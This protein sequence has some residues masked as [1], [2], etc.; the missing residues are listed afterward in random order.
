[1]QF[2]SFRNKTLA[3]EE[4]IMHLIV[5]NRSR[6]SL[7]V[8]IAFIAAMTLLL[9]GWTTCGAIF[10]FNSCPGSV[11][12]PQVA[13]LSLGAIPGDATS[14]LLTVSGSGFVPQS[15]IMWNG[16]ALPT[17]FINSRHLQATI[18]QQTVEPFSGSAESFVQVS[19]RSQ[20]SVAGF[21]CPNGGNSGT[22]VLAIN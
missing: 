12:Q 5:I 15:Q 20:G 8:R 19:V 9:S 14:V 17:T 21:G 2:V 6:P 16:N 1:V 18:T 13:S 11:P 3:T 10:V 7:A 4:A 22:L